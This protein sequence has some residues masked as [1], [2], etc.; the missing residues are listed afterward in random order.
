MKKLEKTFQYSHPAE[1]IFLTYMN[2]DFI[3]DKSVSLGNKNVEVEFEE[4]D[5][6]VRVTI[7]MEVPAEG[8]PGIEQFMGKWNDAEQLEIWT[9]EEGGPYRCDMKMKVRGAPIKISGSMILKDTDAGS[10]ADFVSELKSNFPLLSRRI[11]NF[12]AEKI[13]EGVELECQF[14]EANA[15]DS[16]YL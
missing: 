3:K 12:V 8:P 9:W 13:E 4:E 2:E 7:K 1:Q 16:K 14:I 6:E 5:N 15:A 10:E 11:E